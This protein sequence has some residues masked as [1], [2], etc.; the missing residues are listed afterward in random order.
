MGRKILFFTTD[1]Q[2]YDGLGCN[3]GLIART[4]NIDR[5]AS[6]GVNYRRAHPQSVVCM[7]SRST[8]VTGQHVASHGVWMNGVPLPIDAPS[9]AATLHDAGYA[10]ALIGK[11]H[12]EPFMDPFLRYTENK[13]A[14]SGEFSMSHGGV[15]HR[16][17]DHMESAS[18]GGL[19]TF[20]YA[21]WLAKN[22]P[23]A[24]GMY[25]RVLDMEL[26]VNAAGGGETGGPQVHDNPITREWYHT[27]WVADRAIAWL[28]SLDPDADWF[29]WVSF[30]DPH[31]PW[32]PPSSERHRVNWRELDLPEGYPT[33]AAERE[34]IL[35][36]KPI[37]WRKWYEG[38]F[39]SNY[40]APARWV[41]KTLTTD[42][43][44]EINAL[45]HIEN[46][47]IDE[48]VGRVIRHV[49]QRGWGDDT[50]ILYS[51]DHGELQGDF[52]LMFKGPYHVDSLMRVPLIWRPAPSAGVAPATVDSPV[53][54]VSLASTFCHIAGLPRP[55]YTEADRL[56]ID[57]DEAR[58]L[59]HERVLTEWDS[60]LFG[61][62]LHLRTI[63]RDGWV[64]T[65][66]L[67]GTLHEG[68]EGELYD[69]ANDPLQRVNLWDD[70]AHR[71]TRDDLLADLWDHL[72]ESVARRGVD[73]PV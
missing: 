46:E 63:C 73:A 15:L 65:T 6:T 5:L 17:F 24:I 29:C 59:G 21:Q 13:L 68:H 45:T 41:P 19:G 64:A 66:C 18:H 35:D 9:V 52:G 61:K 11:A 70:P 20:H 44:R 10:T 48:A 7:P 53:G 25:Y 67:P 14:V 42:Q 50:D 33:A 39:Y 26:Q 28:D 55:A 60:V 12:F 34:A 47:L 23:E 4:P 72:P 57:D 49:E 16:G 62:I 30:P 1:Q 32:D 54:H 36:G 27:D 3:G 31:H 69:L 58:T 51:T 43:V 71:A 22:H 37:H 40:E 38:E 8:M 56:P 2:R